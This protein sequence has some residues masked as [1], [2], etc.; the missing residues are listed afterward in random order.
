MKI[1][2]FEK[3]MT[4]ATHGRCLSLSKAPQKKAAINRGST[5][6]FGF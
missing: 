5:L 6:N 4:S 3:Q 1:A 2:I